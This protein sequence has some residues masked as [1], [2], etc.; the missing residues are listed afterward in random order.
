MSTIRLQSRLLGWFLMGG[1]LVLAA[2]SGPA[3]VD[4]TQPP[5]AESPAPLVIS[6]TSAST[7]PVV[8]AGA[9]TPTTVV[10]DSAPTELPEPPEPPEPASEPT[11]QP[12]PTPRAELKAS[13]PE[14][15][16]LASGKLQF[17]EFFAYW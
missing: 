14:D 16:T 12:P 5:L 4:P 11:E 10:A 8:P 6:P 17:V 1:L 3:A 15:I 9:A 7:E 13:N 2:C